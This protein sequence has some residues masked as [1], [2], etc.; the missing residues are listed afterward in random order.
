MPLQ[1]FTFA[2]QIQ[3]YRLCLISKMSHRPK[4]TSNSWGYPSFKTQTG[5]C[6][7]VM[8]HTCAALIIQANH[9]NTARSSKLHKPDKSNVSS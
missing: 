5:G 6:E 1:A 3:S 4:K 2:S 8:K 7:Q 9:H